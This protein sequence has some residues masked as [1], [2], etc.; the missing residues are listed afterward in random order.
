MQ[1]SRD[2]DHIHGFNDV[3]QLHELPIKPGWSGR[4]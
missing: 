2:L 3:F 4:L 1:A